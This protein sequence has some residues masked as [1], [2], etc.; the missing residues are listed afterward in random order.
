MSADPGI[1][2][3]PRGR[4]I[5]LCRVC[6]GV[7]RGIPECVGRPQ[8]DYEWMI[9]RGVRPERA[10]TIIAAR[11]RTVAGGHPLPPLARPPAD[12]RSLF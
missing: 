8:T 3:E 10:E 5:K 2:N 7:H 12:Q 9:D 1:D 6:H 11:A 4:H